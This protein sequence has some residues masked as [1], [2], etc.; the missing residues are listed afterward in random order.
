MAVIVIAEDD[1]DIRHVTAHFLEAAGHTVIA[2]GDGAEASTAVRDH[3]PDAVITDLQMPRMTGLALC[4]AVRDDPRL[5]RT[6]VLVFSGSFD[7][8]QTAAEAG[9]TAV[10]VKPISSRQLVRRLN[11]ELAHPGRP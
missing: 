11:A 3:E 9:V 5:R 6:P 1:E 2:T 10:L 7:L 4:R 8:Q